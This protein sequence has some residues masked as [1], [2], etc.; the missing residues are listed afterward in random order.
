MHGW[1]GWAAV[2]GRL[3][4][5]CHSAAAATLA[6][7]IAMTWLYGAAGQGTVFAVECARRRGRKVTGA[8]AAT[9][10]TV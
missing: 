5:L 9:D 1:N 3:G 4:W 10:S 7:T 2:N 6:G 8:G